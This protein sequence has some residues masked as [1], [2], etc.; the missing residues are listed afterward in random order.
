MNK[1]YDYEGGETL[2]KAEHIKNMRELIKTVSEL[3]EDALNEYVNRLEAISEFIQNI[4][5]FADDDVLSATYF[6]YSN[7]FTYELI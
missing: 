7:K 5:N 3:P 6:E 4:E 1:Y 2:T